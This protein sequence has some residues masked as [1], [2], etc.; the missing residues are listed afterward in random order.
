MT[1]SQ[2]SD[3]MSELLA[4]MCLGLAVDLVPTESEEEVGRLNL[5][6]ACA[7]REHAERDAWLASLPRDACAS[8]P[9]RSLL[10]AEAATRAALLAQG[11]PAALAA[12]TAAVQ[13]LLG[14]QVLDAHRRVC[15]SSTL[16]PTFCEISRYHEARAALLS[17]SETDGAVAR[18][19]AVVFA[20]NAGEVARAR[21][22]ATYYRSDPALSAARRE[23][24]GAL[25]EGLP[26]GAAGP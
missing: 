9:P 5:V 2:L 21:A 6:A 4:E 3:R 22:L 23:G 26:E 18:A 8:P 20:L 1:G 19:A 24:L 13:A 17:A 7:L 11:P 16:G 15:V 12:R 10:D 25:I 14:Y